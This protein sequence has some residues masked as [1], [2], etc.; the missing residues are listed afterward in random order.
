MP[1][2]DREIADHYIPT[3]LDIKP[4]KSEAS[5]I[6]ARVDRE[7]KGGNCQANPGLFS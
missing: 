5:Q 3:Y 6:K 2:L 1:G 4:V 7:D